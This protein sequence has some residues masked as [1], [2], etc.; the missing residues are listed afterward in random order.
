MPRVTSNTQQD[1]FTDTSVIEDGAIGA[2]ET[3]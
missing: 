1:R 2:I 3:S